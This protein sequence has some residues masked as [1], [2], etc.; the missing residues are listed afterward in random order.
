MTGIEE[1]GAA[2]R[3]IARRA[4]LA[5]LPAP[6]LLFLPSLAAAQVRASH[7]VVVPKARLDAL[8]AR[9]YPLFN[10][11]A[12]LPAAPSERFA[13]RHDVTLH[14]LETV[15]RVPETGERVRVSG[16]LAVPVGVRGRLPIV[17]WQHGT[18]LSF[19]QV[20]SNL[21]KLADLQVELSDERDSLETLFNLHRLAGQGFAVIAA[22]YLGKGPWRGS[23]GE[24]YAVKGAT[25][26]CC[27]DILEAGLARLARLGHAPGPLFLNGWSQGGLNTQWLTQ[28]LQAQG[29]PALAAAAQSPFHNL[30]ESMQYWTG[31]TPGGGADYPAIPNWVSLALVTLLGSY[32]E[33]LRLP[34]LFQDAIRAEYR[35]AAEGWWRRYDLRDPALAALPPP[36]GLLV[37]GFWQGFTT[38]AN[39]RF[40]RALAAGAASPFVYARPLRLYFGMADE[41]L[42]PRLMG[43]ALAG[44]GRAVEAMP[45]PG[46]SHRG[47][48]LASLYGEGTVV[49]GRA[50]V[51]EWFRGL[52]PGGG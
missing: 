33:Y 50:T 23:R 20:P 40:L 24:A 36:S 41:A 21:L 28:A 25:V 49:G 29:R 52:L 6:A 32:R 8:A 16:L 37:E 34:S 18:I 51:P 38:D 2:S 35:D 9:A 19:D 7:P 42:P 10:R 22:D 46:A 26:R 30:V 43:L 17:S 3:G 45:V 27:L 31:T 39:S 44:G 4:A 47:T 15:T 1:K 11:P 12:I 5:A 13:A 14:R 48:F